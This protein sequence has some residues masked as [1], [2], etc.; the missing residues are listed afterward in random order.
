MKIIA[1][2]NIFTG[3]TVSFLLNNVT[4]TIIIVI[5]HMPAR[6]R[7]PLKSAE[8]KSNNIKQTL[9]NQFAA[10]FMP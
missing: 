2:Q 6:I 8:K 4:N 7:Y 5:S 9:I 3:K 10:I 1:A